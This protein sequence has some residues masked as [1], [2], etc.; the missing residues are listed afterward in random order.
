MNL[1]KFDWCFFDYTFKKHD[2][3]EVKTQ[4]HQFDSYSSELQKHDFWKEI[5][6]AENAFANTVFI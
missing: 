2:L 5:K 1:H 4:Q 3:N 6:I